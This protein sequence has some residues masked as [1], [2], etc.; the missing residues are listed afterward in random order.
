VTLALLAVLVYS[1]VLA[2]AVLHA[3][4]LGALVA[5]IG[6]LGLIFLAFV[7]ARGVE[8]LLPA[9][10]V[11]LGGAYAVAVI[12]HGASVDER[13]PLVAAG[14]L[15]CCELSAWSVD[16][17]PRVAAERAV[18]RARAA[19]LAAL[20]GGALTARRSSSRSPPR[21]RAAASSGRSPAQPR[22]CS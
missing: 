22:R 7:L 17:R 6:L 12:V 2:D 16:E 9:A 8:E 10:M 4:G 11:C 5:E 18:V 13:A 21:R 15:L 14:L 1:A 20:T 19:A 3:R